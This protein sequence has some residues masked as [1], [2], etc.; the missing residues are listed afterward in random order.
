VW[1][2]KFHT[3]E[4]KTKEQREREKREE[5]Q[6]Q[7]RRCDAYLGASSVVCGRMRM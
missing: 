3:S 4:L 5:K 2:D 1:K 6:E 7:E